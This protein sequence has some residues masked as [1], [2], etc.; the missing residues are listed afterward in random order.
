MIV[1]ENTNVIHV[2]IDEVTYAVTEN[3][4]HQ[5]L[6]CQWGIAI[7]HLDYLAPN[8]AKYSSKCYAHYMIWMYLALLICLRHVE[9]Y[10]VSAACY[11]T[12]DQVLVQE[13]HE[14]LHGI[15]ILQM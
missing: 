3:C 15:F 12:S 1:C 4:C 2:Y 5:A 9:L 8:S 11:I 6:K 14:I 7:Y 10:P 13:G